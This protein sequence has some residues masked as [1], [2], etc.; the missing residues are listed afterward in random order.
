ME[1]LYLS[2]SNSCVEYV[3]LD[4]P[5]DLYLF[6]CNDVRFTGYN[7][8][9]PNVLISKSQQT[10]PNKLYLP[11]NETSMSFK[12]KTIYEETGMIFD[13]ESKKET[14]RYN[15]PVFFFIYNVENYYHFIYDSLPYL[16]FYL[17]LR[18]SDPSI[19]LLIQ[20]HS[21]SY[22]E[23]FPFVMETL[24]LLHITKEDLVFIDGD[25]ETIYEKVYISSS[26]TH[27]DKSN[28]PPN[29]QI[30]S[31][32]KQ[33]I[34]NC[35]I[36]ESETVAP[37]EKMYVSRRSYLHNNT[38]NIGTNYTQRRV[39]KEETELVEYLSTFGFK[40]V[41]PECWTMK[42]KIY[43]FYHAKF[44]VG[45]IGG[46]M[47]NL[48]FSPS[49]TKS[50][51]IVSP[52]FMDINNR[53]KYS[54]EHTQ[55]KY[56][57]D[58]KVEYLHPQYPYAKFQRVKILKGEHKGKYAEIID[59][60]NEQEITC[61]LGSETSVSVMCSSNYTIVNSKD[62]ELIDKGLNSPFSIDMS[63]IYNLNEYLYQ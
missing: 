14:K 58:T 59:V 2:S 3:E 41:F 60:D 34:D 52:Y 38:S 10:E 62:C 20:T 17:K 43:Y 56:I 47:C 6:S 9:Y 44:I 11:Y 28:E 46:G 18:K 61:M 4:S 25:G 32:Y 37:I 16:Y 29:K 13:W 49:T 54:M 22:K 51:V 48:L 31:I 36:T 45:L 33:C 5:R 30:F 8:Y 57:T 1:I 53:F 55:I 21:A 42:E 26:L 24:A 23:C 63:S 27:Q 7:L 15:S 40:E 35:I 19:K 39:L 12:R 50:I